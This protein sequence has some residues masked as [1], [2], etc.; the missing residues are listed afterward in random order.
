MS[1]EYVYRFKIDTD[2]KFDDLRQDPMD[3]LV[4][5]NIRALL[6]IGT[7][8]FKGREVDID[9]FSFHNNRHLNIFKKP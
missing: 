4:I 2:E 3:E 1:K 7:F 5:R 6:E 9:G 8:T